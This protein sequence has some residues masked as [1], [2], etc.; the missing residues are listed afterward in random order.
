MQV[1]D[2]HEPK[3]TEGVFII[4]YPTTEQRIEDLEKKIIPIPRTET[5]A[6]YN[7][8]IIQQISK[9]EGGQNGSQRIFRKSTK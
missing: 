3:Y 9:L 5:E 7:Q 6:R 2:I 8:G 4:L 1:L